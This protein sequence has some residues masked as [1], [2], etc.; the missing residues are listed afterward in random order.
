MS[1]KNIASMR[2]L[3]DSGVSVTDIAARYGLSPRR[4]RELLVIS[5]IAST[6]NP[7][8]LEPG[9]D[10]AKPQA[11]NGRPARNSQDEDGISWNR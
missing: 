1:P 8:R 4:V 9:G 11:S 5:N 10:C 7:V 2:K 3:R 6:P